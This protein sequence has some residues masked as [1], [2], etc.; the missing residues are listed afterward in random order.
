MANATKG[1]NQFYR[2]GNR[3]AGVAGGGGG[4]LGGGAGGQ[5][6][7]K[8]KIYFHPVFPDRKHTEAH[9]SVNL[10]LHSPVMGMKENCTSLPKIEIHVDYGTYR[11]LILNM[12]A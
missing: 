5:V 2:A 7:E 11:R 12:N 9:P 6:Q 4:V 10:P 3:E 8:R 1:K